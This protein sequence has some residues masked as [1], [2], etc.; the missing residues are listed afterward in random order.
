MSSEQK[1]KQRR[2]AK[3]TADCLGIIGSL[4]RSYAGGDSTLY[5]PMAA[6]LRVLFCD[7][8]KKKDH[9]LLGRLMPD[10]KLLAFRAI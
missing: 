6:Q 10:M 3:A 9:S 8:R 2:L 1:R 5:I 7:T 4:M